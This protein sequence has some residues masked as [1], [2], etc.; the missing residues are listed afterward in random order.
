MLPLAARTS[1][2]PPT[3][4]T[5]PAS[6]NG[7]PDSIRQQRS[8]PSTRPLATGSLLSAAV[9]A[10]LKA[11]PVSATT[12]DLSPETGFYGLVQ[13]FSGLIRAVWQH[14][15]GFPSLFKAEWCSAACTSHILHILPSV[16]GHWDCLYLL[17]P[18]NAP[19]MSTGVQI[20]SHPP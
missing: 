12:Q 2:P 19:A 20:P 9:R 14:G 3:Y 8:I 10:P 5:R 13:L 17:A 16:A 15:S 6:H 18:M 1:S 4:R 11:P 7:S